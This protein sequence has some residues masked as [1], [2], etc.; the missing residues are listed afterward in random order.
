MQLILLGSVFFFVFISRCCLGTECSII[1][2]GFMLALS[3][4]IIFIMYFARSQAL[5]LSDNYAYF[6][7]S[8]CGDKL[9]SLI[10]NQFSNS[11]NSSRVKI[12]SVFFMEL[13]ICISFIVR[14][15]VQYFHKNEDTV[16]DQ[17]NEDVKENLLAK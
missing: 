9:T 1:L 5:N 2:D 16:V 4:I 13:C 15:L 7:D 12:I 17:I 11:I 14:I 3:L 8:N 10:L 6:L